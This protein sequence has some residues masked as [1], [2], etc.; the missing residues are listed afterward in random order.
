MH[1]SCFLRLQFEHGCCLSQRTF[2]L[3][4]GSQA[5]LLIAKL[6]YRFR[7]CRLITG[8][9]KIFGALSAKMLAWRP[10]KQRVNERSFGDRSPKLHAIVNQLLGEQRR[11]I[12]FCRCLMSHF[13]GYIW[14]MVQRITS[15][16]I[17]LSRIEGQ[18]LNHGGK[19]QPNPR[20]L[21]HL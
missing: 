12:N 21:G 2:R 16:S 19:Q 11:T 1:W 14:S 17:T 13:S 20:S 8:P 4:H 7:R 10:S 18:V 5:W 6:R 9:R 15:C 3:E